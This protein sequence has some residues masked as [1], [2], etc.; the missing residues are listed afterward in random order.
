MHRWTEFPGLE[1][2]VKQ[3]NDI[4]WSD[5][6]GRGIPGRLVKFNLPEFD[7]SPSTSNTKVIKSD[8]P[9]TVP[10]KNRDPVQMHIK[11][12][13][14][15]ELE[16]G[17][18]KDEIKEEPEDEPGV[19]LDIGPPEPH[20]DGYSYKPGFGDCPSGS[21]LQSTPHSSVSH[22][23]HSRVYLH[24][25]PIFTPFYAVIPY[26]SVDFPSSGPDNFIRGKA[27][28]QPPGDAG[29][30]QLH[31]SS[32][33]FVGSTPPGTRPPSLLPSR[34]FPRPGPPTPSSN[35]QEP[36]HTR[37]PPSTTSLGPAMANQ[38][39]NQEHDKRELP[40]ATD[41]STPVPR[42][43]TKR[44]RPVAS[45]FMSDDEEPQYKRSK[46]SLPADGLPDF[47]K[48]F[49]EQV[50]GSKKKLSH[51]EHVSAPTGNRKGS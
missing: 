3:V 19:P 34:S 9:A 42:R 48:W 24:S 41:T 11:D 2:A 33:R 50:T 16:D 5:L 7:D 10:I 49:Q 31:A 13:F 28:T 15:D 23:G 40:I 22:S 39:R 44:R 6:E 21:L 26:Y 8:D 29:S 37:K 45:D 30:P 27:G 12:E 35:L 18:I 4:T 51:L 36:S 1:T 14:E 46:Q 38:P 25:Q 47:G 43:P 20:Q 17:E 32:P